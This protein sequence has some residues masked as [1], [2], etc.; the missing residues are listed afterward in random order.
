MSV[1]C[2]LAGNRLNSLHLDLYGIG[3][4]AVKSSDCR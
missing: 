3:V 1:I 2:S 4:Y